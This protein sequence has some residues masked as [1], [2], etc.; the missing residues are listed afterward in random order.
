MTAESCVDA[1][2]SAVRNEK[3]EIGIKWNE[4]V[5]LLLSVLYVVS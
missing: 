4:K 1:N 2:V 5:L 3:R